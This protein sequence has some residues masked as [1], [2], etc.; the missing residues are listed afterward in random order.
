M[1]GLSAGAALYRALELSSGTSRSARALLSH[2]FLFDDE[3]Q[4]TTLDNLRRKLEWLATNYDP[5][6]VDD[7]IELYRS[8]AFKGRSVVYTTDDIHRDMFEVHAEFKQFDVPLALFVPV[9]WIATQDASETGLLIELVTLIEWYEGANETVAF[10]EGT[11]LS[12]SDDTKSRN[13]DWI[14]ENREDLEPYF[15][16]VCE[17]IAALEGSHRRRHP[18]REKCNWS[19]IKELANDGAYIG[20]HSISHVS[21]KAASPRRREFELSESKNIL[22]QRLGSCTSFAYPYGTWGVYDESTRLGIENAGYDA[23]FLT[24]S[25]V[26]TQSTEQ[27]DMPRIFIPDHAISVSEFKYRVQGAGIAHQRAKRFAKRS[28]TRLR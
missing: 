17:K 7:L 18:V 1:A 14:L 11:T 3:P 2:R 12:L 28:L 20:S 27:F 6:D 19:E 25:D 26:I 4:A 24:H 21:I 15:P 8:N 10:G 9:G 23:G 22:E 13:I 5:I 16:E